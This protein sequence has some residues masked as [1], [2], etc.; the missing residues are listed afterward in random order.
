M[1]AGE[2]NTSQNVALGWLG[3]FL[4][5]LFAILGLPIVDGQTSALN[6]GTG[7]VGP[8]LLL[9]AVVLGLGYGGRTSPV[10]S[11]AAAGIT[12]IVSIVLSLVI[13]F[14]VFFTVLLSDFAGPVEWG[15]GVAATFAAAACGL[16]AVVMSGRGWRSGSPPSWTPVTIAG[17]A[18]S[19]A[20]VA[21]LVVPPE[22]SNIGEALGFTV[23]PVVGIG[24]TFFLAALAAVAVAGFVMGRWGIGLLL[25][26]FGFI[27][28]GIAASNSTDQSTTL[29]WSGVTGDTDF[30]TFTA[31]GFWSALALIVVHTIQQFSS[32]VASNTGRGAPVWASDPFGRHEHRLFDGN[33][34]TDQVS[35]QGSQSPDPAVATKPDTGAA[36]WYPDPFGRH[37]HR[38]FNGANWTDRVA[39]SGNASTAPAT[40]PNP[41]ASTTPLPVST[42]A[43]A[44][45]IDETIAADH[46]SLSNSSGSVVADV[47]PAEA[48]GS[49]VPDPF[50]RHDLRFFDGDIWTFHVSNQGVQAVDQ[51][52]APAPAG[53]ADWHPDPFGRHDHRF[54]DGKA[55]TD[56][57]A[58]GGT[59]HID[60]A[61]PSRPQTNSD[62]Q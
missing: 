31:I 25:G 55:W 30:S 40:F 15:G 24:F 3:A 17:S 62:R 61:T 18:A 35:D 56:Q 26:F 49:W 39:T 53:G 33:A 43:S 23:H 32:G 14:G 19:V 60:P 59:T 2:V 1:A 16:I 44:A 37:E 27:L 7:E 46:T 8:F 21:G 13:T 58:T 47:A 45:A 5:A 29:G 10:L 36:D 9:A 4:V 22:G 38:F 42:A 6:A 51:P 20:M 57:A 34:W 12:A 50:R 41:K 52:L 28:A 48:A 54:F 11:G